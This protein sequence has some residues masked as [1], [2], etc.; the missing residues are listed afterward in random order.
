LVIHLLLTFRERPMPLQVVNG[1]KLVCTFGSIPSLLVVLPVHR[2]FC[3]NQL[4][5]NIQDHV[6][7]VNILPFGTCTGASGA[8]CVPA[9]ALPWT[10]GAVTVP[11]DGSP[12]LDDIS[13]CNCTVGGIVK[14]LDAG[15]HQ[16]FIP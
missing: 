6:P 12:A 3:G 13:I 2:V 5:A 9:T 16:T 10:P 1:A 7:A 8:P 4:A 14:V 15:Q 11:L